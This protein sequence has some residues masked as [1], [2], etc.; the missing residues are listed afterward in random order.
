MGGGGRRGWGW[1]KELMT[2]LMKDRVRPLRA[3]DDDDQKERKKRNQ[4]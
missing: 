1:L 4:R 3:A 2:S